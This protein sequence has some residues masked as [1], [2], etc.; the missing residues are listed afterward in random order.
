MENTKSFGARTLKV[1]D[2]LLVRV[3]TI[4]MAIMCS[5][6]V[7]TV[8]L[9]YVFN[10]TYVWSEELIILLF[11]CTTY[12]GSILCVKE[13]EHIDIP[14]VRESVS[15]RVGFVMDIIVCLVNIVIQVSLAYISIGW[16][17]KT[18]SSVSPGLKIPYY[19]IY[20]LFPF[21]F[22][23]MSVYTI[24]RLIKIISARIE[25]KKGGGK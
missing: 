6:V 7:I 10:L 9:R 15:D 3:S 4:I 21:G 24:R 14:F 11:I 22:L 13:K 1:I 19:Y 5:L 16:I 25:V 12:F 20:S 8:I 2:K 23:S 17:V 18:G